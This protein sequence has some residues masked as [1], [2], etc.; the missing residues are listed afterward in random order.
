MENVRVRAVVRCSAAA[1]FLIAAAT[2][3]CVEARAARLSVDEHTVGLWHFD[4]ESGNIAHDESPNGNHGTI[5]GAT[6][7]TG[8]F[9]SALAFDGV[10]DKVEVPH[11]PSLDFGIN[12]SFTIEVWINRKPTATWPGLVGRHDN[13]AYQWL[14]VSDRRPS[15]YLIK[16]G[17]G[18]SHF[19][20]S[21]WVSEDVWTHIAV[22][23]DGSGKQVLSYID[24]VLDRSFSAPLDYNLSSWTSLLIGYDGYGAR[25]FHGVMDEVRLSN[26]ARAAEEMA[27]SASPN[28]APVADAG[29][30]L[31]AAWNEGA[32][33]DGAASYDPEGESL[34]YA[35]Y[36]D[37]DNDGV[38]EE[39]EKIA[40]EAAP[41][42]SYTEADIGVHYYQLVVSDGEF[43]SRP[44][45]VTVGV[46]DAAED[47]SD[48]C[49]DDPAKTEPGACGCGV[50][51]TDSDG[52]AAPDCID[53]CPGDPGKT[54]AG[55]CGCGAAD[56]DSDGD[57]TPDCFDQCPADAGKIAPAVCGCGAIDDAD[58]DGSF[59][60]V[61]DCDDSAPAV[62]PGAEETCYDGLDNDCDGVIDD[63]CVPGKGQDG[64]GPP[65]VQKASGPDGEG[66]PG[67]R[68]PPPG[69]SK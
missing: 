37:L 24:G 38:L 10:N 28:R 62:H 33:L 56:A 17:G 36:E 65:G 3:F 20:S 23:Y 46:T 15:L 39:E 6:W 32:V 47:C 66:P 19:P 34:A 30:D 1:V 42:L 16:E 43:D 11:D 68:I 5:L 21:G 35:W 52:D 2:A 49:P 59:A 14:L 53:D 7:T 18:F 54:R 50:A 60:C 22:V 57:L 40:A 31:L 4:E 12:G 63:G 44:D 45:S 64:E 58:G 61:D 25:Y 26:V 48:L 8:M 9:G 41:A 69:R 51:D 13:H 55:A 29:S 27:E 67:L